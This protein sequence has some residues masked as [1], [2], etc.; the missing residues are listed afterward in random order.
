MKSA[1]LILLTSLFASKLVAC[2]CIEP[3]PALVRAEACTAVF[4][5]R[6]VSEELRGDTRIYTFE[7]SELFKGSLPS[8]L[9]ISTHRDGATCGSKF[10]KENQYLVFCRG[11]VP[12]SLTTGLCSANREVTSKAGIADLEELRKNK[13]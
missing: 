3:P 7:V 12:T 10:T 6:V 4:V 8:R 2:S 1:L 5:G 13:N 9:L 11:D